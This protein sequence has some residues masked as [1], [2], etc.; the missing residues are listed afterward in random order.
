M[1][2][3]A[4]HG[5][6]EREKAACVAVDNLVADVCNTVVV[7]IGGGVFAA[8]GNEMLGTP[9]DRNGSAHVAGGPSVDRAVATCLVVV[10][11][12]LAG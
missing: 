5:A 7:H 12:S 9:G 1:S 4:V 6:L 11:H 8:V 10:N 3:P 2:I